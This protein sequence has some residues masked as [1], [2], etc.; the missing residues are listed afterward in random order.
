[1]RKLFT[2]TNLTL[3]TA[4]TL[5]SI[6]AWYSIL[7]LTAI[8][9]AA[10]L[11]IIIMGGALEI[12]KVVTTVWLHKF[13][14]KIN[15]T[16]KLYLVPAV[17]V[18]AF[19]TSMGIFGF[20]SK[21]HIEQ[22]VPTGDVAAKVVLIDEK[23]KIQ[24]ENIAAARSALG[25][26]DAQVNARLD[27]GAT[28]QGAERAVQIRRQQQGER[29]RLLKEINDAQNII[30]KLNEE[31]APIA[32]ELRK[33]EAEVGPI[34]YIA[35]LI[36]GNNPDQSLLEEA[37]R[38]VIV[39]IV[40]VFDPL[41]L[42]LVL[43]ANS[44][45]KWEQEIVVEEIKEEPRE[46]IKIE[47]E[48]MKI[49]EEPVVKDFDIK[50]H[51]Y[52]FKDWTWFSTGTEHIKNPPA[53]EIKQESKLQESEPLLEKEE[54]V[55]VAN[56]TD[57]EISVSA[58]IPIGMLE[59]D[60]I[61]KPEIVTEGVTKEIDPSEKPYKEINEDYVSYEGKQVRKEAL[62]SLHPELFLTKADTSDPV[63]T[64]FGVVFPPQ[65]KKGQIFVRVDILPNRVYK[66]DGSRWIEIKKDQSD[67]YLHNQKY[68]QYLVEKIEKGEY[69]V[70]LLSETEKEE[71]A[72]Y[73]G[74]QKS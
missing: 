38:W 42:C 21:A 67:S 64:D 26:M 53:E 60:P 56:T 71:I 33:V 51:P 28:E 13:W 36:Y 66:F 24:R 45:R 73:L 19:L 27:R 65:A 14:H 68:I 46:E 31:R 7:G 48:K 3:L 4:L 25:Q 17:I 70:D 18:L 63:T 40:L 16:L 58:D 55:V 74:N 9:A 6:A 37:V 35:A 10:A 15:L 1:M 32:S 20:L 2:L 62:K 54:P 69:D 39:L 47:E 12:A 8:F 50:D 34:K 59:P 72:Q 11:P 43:A 5:S 44:S 61:Q 52:L 57:S 23:I 29:N 22:S 41:A 49:K 30:T